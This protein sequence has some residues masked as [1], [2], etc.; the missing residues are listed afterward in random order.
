VT[1]CS[2]HLFGFAA[3]HTAAE[4]ANAQRSRYILLSSAAGR[5]QERA[6]RLAATE[7][8]VLVV[9]PHEER[10][11][12]GDDAVLRTRADCDDAQLVELKRRQHLHRARRVF[13]VG[14]PAQ[15]GAR[16]MVLSGLH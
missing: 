10:V 1:P 5:K 3:P 9:A 14:L 6:P 15:L 16:C 12:G 13:S 4:H 11:A 8:A 2:P 7:L